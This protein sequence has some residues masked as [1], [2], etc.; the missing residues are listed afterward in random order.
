[1]NYLVIRS[2]DN[3]IYANILLLRLKEEG[4]DC[5]LKDENTITIDPLLSPAIG[6]MTLLVNEAEINKVT[7]LLDQIEFEY[8]KTL[9]CPNC[10]R[11]GIQRL[12]KNIHPKNLFSALV[13]NLINGSSVDK[14][15]VYRCSFCGHNIDDPSELSEQDI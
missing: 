10:A 12:V 11:P 5:Y 13:A 14:R 1:M 6:G 8:L 3:Y 4:I 15:I 9:S 2:F 7:L